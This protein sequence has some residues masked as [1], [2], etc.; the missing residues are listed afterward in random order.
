[1]KKIFAVI[2][3]LSVSVLTFAQNA[4]DKISFNATDTS[5]KSV[6]SDMFAKNKVT[7]LNIWGTFCGPCIRKM[8]DLA[9]LCDANKANGVEV[10]GIVID[11]LD[12]RGNINS[13]VKSSGESIIKQTEANYTHII[14]TKEMFSGFLRN[15]QVVPTT[16]FVDSEWLLLRRTAS[17]R[18]TDW[19][20]LP[21]FSKPERLA[22]NHR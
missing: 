14:P 19:R 6:S 20:S 10:V 18:K 17:R 12:R 22:E 21:R 16:I 5:G 7:M 1:M 8:P 13:R 2:A 9:K 11:I 3:M 4:G 15:V